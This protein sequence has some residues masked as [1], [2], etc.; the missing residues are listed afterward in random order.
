MTTFTITVVDMFTLP[1]V[2][3]QADVVVSVNYLMTGVDGAHT[4]SIEFSQQFTL[5]QDVFTPYSELT[6]SQVIGWVGSR[7]VLY[8]QECVQDSLAKTIN[9]PVFPASQPLPWGA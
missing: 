2:N 8:M 7:T 5:Q 3:G 9:P 1:Q 4:A 6:Q